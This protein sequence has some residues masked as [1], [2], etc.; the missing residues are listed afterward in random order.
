MREVHRR[1]DAAIE[2]PHPFVIALEQL[3]KARLRAR[4]PF[5]PAKRQRGAPIV[6]IHQVEHE[7]LHPERCPLA[8]GRE[9]GGLQVRIA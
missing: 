5:D 9:L 8:D 3:E 7:V 2:L 4:R 6:E 1:G